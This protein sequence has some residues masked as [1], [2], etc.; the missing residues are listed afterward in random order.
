MTQANN[1]KAISNE[2]SAVARFCELRS[3]VI[4]LFADAEIKITDYVLTH[5]AKPNVATHPLNQKINHALKVPAGPQRS[6]AIKANADVELKIVQELLPDRAAIV[7]SRMSIAK[8]VSGE[9][10]A[11]FKNAK[12][13]VGG[14]NNALVYNEIELTNFLDRLKKTIINLEAALLAKNNPQQAA[15]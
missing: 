8:C 13:V 15:Q 6:K 10:V 5:A 12:D 14:S 11:I 4:D 2:T 7:H 3:S 1:N 9:F